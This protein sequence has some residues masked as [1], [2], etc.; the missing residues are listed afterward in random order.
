MP[1]F[2]LFPLDIPTLALSRGLMQVMLAGLLVYVGGRHEH[3]NGARLWAAGFLLNGASLFLFSITAHGIWDTVCVVGNHLAL[4]AG[5]ACLLL[6]FWAFGRQRAQPWLAALMVAIPVVALLAFEVAWP[7]ARLRVLTTAF[8]QLVFLL[9]LQASLRR[10]PRHEIEHIY[11]RLRVLAL[12]YAAVLVWSYAVVANV[13]PTSSRLD[14][15]YHLA[16]FSVAS[17]LFMLSLAVTCLALQFALLAARN[18]DLAMVDWLT[19]L[20]NRRGFF[21][22]IAHG[23]TGRGDAERIGS[24]VV[25]DID[26]FKRI[27]DQHGHAAGDRV[28]QAVADRLRE[29][30]SPS[31]LV[32][33]MGGEEFCIAMPGAAREHAFARAEAILAHCRN[34]TVPTDDGRAIRFTLSAGVCEAEPGQAIDDALAKADA[35]MYAAKREGRDRAMASMPAHDRA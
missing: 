30:A 10:P 16:I 12:V 9:A 24:V 4:G 15:G 31:D 14:I 8:G 13:L 19:G 7:N 11:R 22:A 23:D 18:E 34:T 2:S 33:R 17:L 27:N 28:L 21:R 6:G 20:L 29:L 1:D 25:L 35:A 32:A 5:S 26:H 3:G